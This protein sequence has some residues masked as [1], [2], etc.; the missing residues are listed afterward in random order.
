MIRTPVLITVTLLACA[1]TNVV[2]ASGCLQLPVQCQVTS[3]FGPRYD[4]VKKDYST[5]QHKGVDFGCPIGTPVLSAT[6]GIVKIAGYSNSAGN[7]V[8]VSANGGK[9]TLK[10]FHHSSNRVV[11]GTLVNPG[12]ELALSGNTGERTTGPHLHFQYESGGLAFNPNFCTTPALRPGVLQGQT[13]SAPNDANDRSRQATMP[14]DNGGIPPKMG[15][16]GGL[17]EIVADLIGSRATNPDYS[18]QLATLSEPRLYAEIAYLRSVSLKIKHE[19]NLQ[20]ERILATQAMI[21]ALLAEWVLKPQLEAQRSAG[22]RASMEN[23]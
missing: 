13:T 22:V 10:Y 3:T 12:Q 20:R 8:V 6:P 23:R 19:R 2:E 16:E 1:F 17:D 4:P 5:Q 18:A 14:S 15:F 9:D 11:S 7:W 21:Q